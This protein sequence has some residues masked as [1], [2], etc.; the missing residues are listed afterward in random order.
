[1]TFGDSVVTISRGQSITG[2]IAPS[3]QFDAHSSRAAFWDIDRAIPSFAIS[4]TSM[5]SAV[6]IYR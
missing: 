1:V 5:V 4:A 3:Q 6:A 2:T